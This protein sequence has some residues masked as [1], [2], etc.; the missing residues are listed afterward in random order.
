MFLTIYEA[1]QINRRTALAERE[2]EGQEM[3]WMDSESN[4]PH[5]QLIFLLLLLFF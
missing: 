1:W 2:E 3:R 5:W 4:L